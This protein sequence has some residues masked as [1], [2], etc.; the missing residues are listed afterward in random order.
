MRSD[1]DDV[2]GVR[3]ASYSATPD[4]FLVDSVFGR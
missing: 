3:F 4:Y 2:V 1:G